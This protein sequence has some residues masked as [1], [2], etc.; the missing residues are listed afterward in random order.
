MI[1]GCKLTKL[2]RSFFICFINFT[3]L[4]ERSRSASAPG[5][6]RW[7]ERRSELLARS[8]VGAPL[9]VAGPER[10]RSA[11]PDFAGAPNTLAKFFG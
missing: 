9:R 5:S 11:A 7:S 4:L 10:T 8:A 3:F 2:K 1:G 6:E